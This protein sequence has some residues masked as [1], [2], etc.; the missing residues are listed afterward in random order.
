M[1]N[2]GYSASSCWKPGSLFPIYPHLP[3]NKLTSMVYSTHP[4]LTQK[5]AELCPD[6]WALGGPWA[7]T[8]GGSVLPWQCPKAELQS[9]SVWAKSDKECG[10]ALVNPSSSHPHYYRKWV[11]KTM[12]YWP[13]KRWRHWLQKKSITIQRPKARLR[14]QLGP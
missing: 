7:R 5:Q 13:R 10:K 11:V 3:V 12:V 8:A 6:G 1:A 14:C 2:F 9:I 4:N